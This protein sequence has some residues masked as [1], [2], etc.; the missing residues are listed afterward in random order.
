MYGQEIRTWKLRFVLLWLV[1]PIL[2]FWMQWSGKLQLFLVSWLVSWKLV[3]LFMN[4]WMCLGWSTPNTSYK[5]TWIQIWYAHQMFLLCTSKDQALRTMGCL[6]FGSINFGFA[7]VFC[8]LFVKNNFQTTT[9]FAHD[10][11]LFTRLWKGLTIK[12]ILFHDI[13]K[14]T[15]LLKIASVKIIRSMEDEHT[16]NTKSLMKSKL[17]NRLTTH[18][19]LVIHMFS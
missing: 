11:N 7:K 8:V 1:K 4:S 3:L 2:L 17:R 5:C 13:P 19:D 10:I 18:L 9:T 15:K 12:Q 14:Y 16:F 6:A